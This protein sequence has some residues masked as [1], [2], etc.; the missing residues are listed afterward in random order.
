MSTEENIQTLILKEFPEVQGNIKVQRKRRIQLDVDYAHFEKMLTF[1]KEKQDFVILCTIT[2][3]DEGNAF[4]LI[5]HIAREDG[6][7]LNLKTRVPRENPVVKTITSFFPSAE[8]S[9]RE[10]KDLFGVNVEGLPAG[11]RYPLPDDW[12]SDEYPLRK[13]WKP[14]TASE[15]GKEG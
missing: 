10:V 15:A 14:K 7:V 2:G 5:Y 11:K 8:I 3:L 6:I 13:D 9:E 4:A 1:L 12:P